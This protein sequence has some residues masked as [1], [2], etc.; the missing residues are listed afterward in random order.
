MY[1]GK[2]Y[3]PAIFFSH[4]SKDK[5]IILT[6]KNKIDKITGGVLDIFMSSD[7]Q[8]IPLG[9]NWV[10]KIEEGLNN[11]K[12]MFVFVTPNSIASEWIYFEAG[13]AYSKDIEVIPVGVGIDIT[14]L[15][16]PLNLLQGFNVNSADS[17]N[18]F[19]SVINKKFEYKFEG[20]F[21]E[22]D[23]KLLINSTSDYL[24]LEL[25]FV[26]DSISYGLYREYGVE[27]A[28]KLIYEI[29][30]YFL[31][32]IEFLDNKSIQYTYSDSYRSLENKCL[33]V[34]GIKILYN[35]G[36]KNKD[37]LYSSQ[38]DKGYINFEISPY[39]FKKSFD[40]YKE[41]TL[42]YKD[43]RPTYLKIKLSNNYSF[44]TQ[45]ENCSAVFS[46]Y[47]DK[48][49]FS[50]TK[51]GRYIYGSKNIDFSIVANNIINEDKVSSEYV[52][53]ITYNPDT[54][55]SKDIIDLIIT[56]IEIKIIYRN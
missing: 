32:I 6:L 33:L 30:D 13:F 24:N 38:M 53:H 11:A 23:F 42:L 56:L 45:I 54:I 4:S 51:I 40:L 25:D 41:I 43:K 12:I 31:K 35:A 1:G 49:K 3:K 22:I 19:I 14:L 46:E 29:D 7:G 26:L 48:F 21:S 2:M 20:G 44:V 50:E 28:G 5:N 10:H 34:Y 39:N 9:S 52:L 8:S 15:K 47:P 18:N 55:E 17:L 27:K 36:K 37:D 16:A